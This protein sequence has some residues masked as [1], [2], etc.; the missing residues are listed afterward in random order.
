M[1]DGMPD[2]R[3]KGKCESGVA[4]CGELGGRIVSEELE[5]EEGMFYFDGKAKR[6]IGGGETFN[7]NNSCN[8]NELVN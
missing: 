7:N 4:C 6:R 8:S 5:G 3:R 1:L 2:R